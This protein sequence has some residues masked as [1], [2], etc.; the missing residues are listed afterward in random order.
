MAT[1][2]KAPTGGGALVVQER[3]SGPVF[4]AKWRDEDTG[5]QV[6]RALGPAWVMRDG[7]PRASRAVSASA[8]RSSGAGASRAFPWER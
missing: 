7:D 6:K 4:C 1:I 8:A 2:E 5:R 3:A